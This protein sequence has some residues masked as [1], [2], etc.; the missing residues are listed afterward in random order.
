M[1]LQ[2]GDMVK[3]RPQS[4]LGRK[5]TNA[6]GSEHEVI[7]IADSVACLNGEPGMLLR[8]KRTGA[9]RW[10]RQTYDDDFWWLKD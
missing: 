8:S 3:L 2:E 4:G 9:Q 10:I 7:S 6:N 1:K 5:I